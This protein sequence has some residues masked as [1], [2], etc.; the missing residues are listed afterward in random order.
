MCRHLAYVGPATS[1]AYPLL[2]APNS[3]LHQSFA[4][5][6]MRSGAVANADGFGLGW[7]S[8][9]QAH[10]YRRDCPLWT[11]QGIVAI[12]RS[13]STTGYLAAARSATTGMPVVE[14]ACAPFTDGRWLFSH[15]GVITGWPA[16]MAGLAARLS[17]VD[18]MTLEA[19]TDSALLWALLR[20]RLTEGQDPAAALSALVTEVERHAPGSRL[21]LLLTDGSTVYATTW[22]H[23]LSLRH[24]GNAVLVSSEPVDEDPGWVAV[25]D[26]KLV[27]ATP[28]EIRIGDC[29]EMVGTP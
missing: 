13:T 22:T 26:R 27:I 20:A 24:N 23:S 2:D 28:A 3:L 14:T 29:A 8:D 19:P 21:N 11:D 25:E 16:T 18:L 1:P 4:P 15:N 17:T 12:A 5:H 9:G 7:I 6:D 10:R